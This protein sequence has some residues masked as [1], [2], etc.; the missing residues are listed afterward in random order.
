MLRELRIGP[1]DDLAD[2]GVL[3]TRG[4]DLLTGQD[5]FVTVALG[6]GLERC[7]V[8]AGTRLRE[9]LAPD[10][11]AA[12]H[13]RQVA[14]LGGVAAMGDD[15]RRHH[16]EPDREVVLVR[17]LVLGF[18]AVPQ[19]LVGVGER[20]AAMGLRAGDPSEA[21]VELLRPPRTGRGELLEL[22]VPLPLLEHR[23]LVGAFTPDELLLGFLA[24]GVRVEE[25][26]GLLCEG[27]E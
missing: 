4:P 9:E 22:P 15:G 5:P 24:G 26:A 8:G 23:D 20:S 2:V 19:P 12:V 27:V 6:P 21:G 17:Y 11:I 3:R 1:G 16:A 7:E 14:V 10:E 13:R 18:E 25:A